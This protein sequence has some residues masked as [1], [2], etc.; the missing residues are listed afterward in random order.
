MLVVPKPMHSTSTNGCQNKN[1]AHLQLLALDNCQQGRSFHLADMNNLIYHS[2]LYQLLEFWRWVTVMF[3]EGLYKHRFLK[4][5]LYSTIRGHRWS[6]FGPDYCQMF[7]IY[8]LTVW[9]V[10]PAVSRQWSRLSNTEQCDMQQSQCN[11]YHIH[12]CFQV[13]VANES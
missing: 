1:T 3:P 13:R 8:Y 6:Q 10:Q 12:L 2:K 9:A 4:S 5:S 11:A 7:F